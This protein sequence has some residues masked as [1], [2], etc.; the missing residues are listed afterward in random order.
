M[1][2]LLDSSGRV[3]LN[4]GSA[5]FGSS[6][7]G[8]CCYIEA[9]P[10]TPGSARVW[11][12]TSAIAPLSGD[13]RMWFYFPSSS[14][15]YSVAA[16]DA[17]STPPAISFKVTSTPSDRRRGCPAITAYATMEDTHIVSGC[18]RDKRWFYAGDEAYR[19][20]C[21]GGVNPL[22]GVASSCVDSNRGNADFDFTTTVNLNAYVD[23]AKVQLRSTASADNSLVSITINGTVNSLSAGSNILTQSSGLII[24]DNTFVFRIRNTGGPEGL[25][26]SW[27]V[28][29]L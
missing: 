12:A 8:C 29:M 23:L 27:S 2:I 17:Q 1:P 28:V 10:C 22:N 20:L 21:C 26:A 15:F 5:R 13:S 9:T 18:V 4:N 11:V 16:T 19:Y 7:D 24:G 25:G 3:V 6:G 14:A